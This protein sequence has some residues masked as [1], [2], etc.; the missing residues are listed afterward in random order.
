MKYACPYVRRHKNSAALFCG[1][2][3]AEN[4]PSPFCA[5]QYMCRVTNRWENTEQSHDC[6]LRPDRKGTRKQ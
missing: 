5:H 3:E 6:P 4:R 2:L 1:I